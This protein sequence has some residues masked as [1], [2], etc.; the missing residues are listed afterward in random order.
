MKKKS[1]GWLKKNSIT[2]I[3]AISI[4]G[5]S[6]FSNRLPLLSGG[7]DNLQ[8][9]LTP[10]GWMLSGNQA[11]QYFT[12]IDNQ[13]AE[14]GKQSATLE[15]AIQNPS[16]FCTLMQSCIQKDFSGKR[17]KMTGYIKSQNANIA[18]MWVRVDDYNKKITAD[19]D[20]MM[21]RPVTG[22]N[23][24]TKCEIVF[25]ATSKCDVFYGFILNGPG[26]IWVDNVSFEVV[27][28]SVNKTAHSLNA[29]LPDAY[30]Q[31]I[32]KLPQELPEKPPVNLDFEDNE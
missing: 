28:S 16:G 3:A 17:I 21:D 24:W 23:D 13:I 12:G 14:H 10:Y 30:L 15:S 29:D 6:A 27:D 7:P 9:Q 26:K 31:Q 20:N 32:D 11:D 4:L 25:D 1:P 5:L 19:F 22:T 18:T 8:Q 2:L